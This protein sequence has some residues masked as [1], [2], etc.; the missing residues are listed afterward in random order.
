MLNKLFRFINVHNNQ[1]AEHLINVIS[2]DFGDLLNRSGVF[3]QTINILIEEIKNNEG[4]NDVLSHAKDRILNELTP[5]N[6]NFIKKLVNDPLVQ[7]NKEKVLSVVLEG[8]TNFL[9]DETKI[10]KVINDLNLASLLVTNE[11]DSPINLELINNMI[12]LAIKNPDLRDALKISINDF[13]ERANVYNE[14]QSW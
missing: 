13:I 10:R 4:I 11:Q 3:D 8:I 9:N 7:N 6:F 1:H 14:N 12:V 5:A 2:N